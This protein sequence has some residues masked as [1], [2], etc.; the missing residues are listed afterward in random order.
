[1]IQKCHIILTYTTLLTDKQNNTP[2]YDRQNKEN[3]GNSRHRMHS[4]AARN[5]SK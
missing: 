5:S 1:M 2:Q 3:Y 4:I